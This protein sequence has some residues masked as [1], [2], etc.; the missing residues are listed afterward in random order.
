[1][2][3]DLYND[4][5]DDVSDITC[6]TLEVSTS[7]SAPSTTIDFSLSTLNV[8]NATITGL[9]I[10]T[11]NIADG[12]VTTPKLANQSYIPFTDS[13]APS[14]YVQASINTTGVNTTKF[15]LQDSSVVGGQQITSPFTFQSNLSINGITGNSIL[16]LNGSHLV[17][18]K[19]LTDGQ[20]LIGSTGATPIAAN[21]TSTGGTIA[22]TFGSGSINLEV[23]DHSD[24]FTAITIDGASNQ[25]VLRPSGGINHAITINTTNPASDRTYSLIDTGANSSFVMTDGVQTINSQKIFTGPHKIYAN[26]IQLG[27]SLRVDN[28][29]NFMKAFTNGGGVWSW[30][31]SSTT[32]DRTLTFP[33]SGNLSDNIILST[34]ANLLTGV[35]TF[36][37]NTFMTNG[38]GSM[39]TWQ[40]GGATHK[41]YNFIATEPSV[42]RQISLVDPGADGK[43]VIDSYG[44]TFS[45]ANTFTANIGAEFVNTPTTKIAW[46]TRVTGDSTPRISTQVDGTLSWSSGSASS[47]ITVSRSAAKSLQI[48][49]ST[50]DVVMIANGSF[51]LQSDSATGSVLNITG[52]SNTALQLNLGYDTTNAHSKIDSQASGSGTQLNVNQSGGLVQFGSGGVQFVNSTTSY[53]P[54][55]LNYYEQATVTTSPSGVGVSCL[56]ANQTLIYTRIG[57]IVHCSWVDMSG[58]ASSSTA[59]VFPAS[60]IPTRFLP[61]R[62]ERQAIRVNKAGTDQA[63]TC[64]LFTSGA[65]QIFSD[66]GTGV[67]TNASA[68]IIFATTLTWTTS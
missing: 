4:A 26:Y 55:I 50:N 6:D 36:S 31:I 44:N 9:T 1:M 22:I 42:D 63:G 52:K 56:T 54:A 30:N 46:Q 53:T 47:D 8:T 17:E 66:G 35:N 16:T 21:I 61:V 20:L 65:I 39:M 62:Q 40:V 5:D 10:S 18:S 67:F 64:V 25:I 29:T 68:A 15:I 11:A 14:G 32:T 34:N 19:S 28:V 59:M 3:S 43:L 45:G 41:K 51:F 48:S 13:S 24:V 12:S 60:S 37:N 23:A 58:T 38:A 49:N 7:I 57:N 33:D 27:D 2:I